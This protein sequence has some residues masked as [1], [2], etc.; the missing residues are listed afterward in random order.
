MQRPIRVF[1]VNAKMFDVCMARDG[2]V[3]IRGTFAIPF[4]DEDAA[5]AHEVI[6]YG[7]Q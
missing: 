2:G 6:D 1:V 5:N 4:N 3:A 7:H